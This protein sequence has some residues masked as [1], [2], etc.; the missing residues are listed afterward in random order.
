MPKY[1]V[2]SPSGEVFDVNAPE[3]ASEADAIE[4]VKKNYTVQK[5]ETPSKPFGQK[6]NEAIGDLP[7]QAGLTARYGIEGVGDTFDMLASPIR[8][9]MNAVSGGAIKGRTGQSIADLIGLPTP[10]TGM[11]RIAGDASRML[12]GGMLPVGLAGKLSS[13]AT[14]MA[15]TVAEGLSANPMAQA[16]SATAGGAAGG[17]TRETGG[18][19]VSQLVA[20]LA[21]G[22]AAPMAANKLGNVPNSI[23]NLMNNPDPQAQAI[24]I[25]VTIENALKQSGLTL[26]Q[27]PQHVKN[28]LQADVAQALKISNGELSPD[29]LR[30]LVDYRLTGATPSAAGLTLDPAIVSQQRNLAKI[31]IN[32]K[33]AAAQQL[34][35]IEN[36]NNRQL[37]TG[38][39]NLGA[40]T[41]DDALAGGE[42]IIGALSRRNNTAKKIIGAQYDAA[43]GSAGRSVDLEPSVFAGNLE[44]GLKR[45]NVHAFLPA[46]IRSMVNDFASGKT[47]LNVD[48]A[49][50]FKTI[51]GNLQ[52]TAENGNVRNAL[53]QARSAIDNT[54][55]VAGIGQDAIDAFNRARSL[56]RRWESIVE[57]TPALQA[58][59]DGIEPDKFVQTFIL[60]QGGKA[61]VMDVA[62]LKSSIKSSPEAMQAV[63]DQ[64]VAHLKSKGMNGAADEAVNFSQSGYNT[65]LKAIG[66]RKLNL[67]FKPEEVAQLKAIGRVAGYEQFQPKGSAVNNSNTAG[68]GLASLLDRIGNSPLLSK[69]PLGKLAAEPIQNISTGMLANQ[70]MNVPQALINQMAR[71]PQSQG[72]LMSPMLF[73]QPQEQDGLLTP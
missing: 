67:F 64:I 40:N 25:N 51:V 71:Q 12:V 48:T 10:K 47:P 41:A 22:I 69:I 37:I 60:G 72:L 66:D 44:A 62:R 39:N 53:S 36:A 2:T 31:G 33:D 34:G 6:M 50:Q 68:A 27:L 26:S 20:S 28:G 23:K 30:R 59:R 7:R 73:M 63:K 42:K 45:E 18:D 65:A 57:K 35:Q 16:I 3:G 14:G 9:G 17:Y 4:Y 58:V 49:E 19:D 38:L 70:K 24:T 52:R 55:P 43:K 11:E 29:A 54:P 56:N 32:S 5:G 21:A 13:G 15:K 8:A 1:S 61:N 46:E